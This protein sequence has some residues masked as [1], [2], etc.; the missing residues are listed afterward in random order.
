MSAVNYVC[1][2]NVAAE[3]LLQLHACAA[4]EL[5]VVQ[6]RRTA[7]CTSE[8]VCICVGIGV[9]VVVISVVVIVGLIREE[10]GV[11]GWRLAEGVAVAAVVNRKLYEVAEENWE[12]YICEKDRKKE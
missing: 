11:G 3:A 9:I 8:S 7:L 4:E 1:V 5:L 2:W 6:Q 12:I 10:K